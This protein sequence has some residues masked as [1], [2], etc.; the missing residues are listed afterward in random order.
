[1]LV[2][3]ASVIVDLILDL[4]PPRCG[5]RRTAPDRILVGRTAT[6]WTQRWRACFAIGFCAAGCQQSPRCQRWPTLLPASQAFPS[7]GAA[8]AGV[9]AARQCLAPRRAL[10][11]SRWDAGSTHAD[12]R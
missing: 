3:D 10:P 12:A 4:P 1:V 11:G 5:G 9:R 8:A 6:C 2:V 7:H